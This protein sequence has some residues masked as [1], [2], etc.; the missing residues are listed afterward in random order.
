MRKM[1][2]SAATVLPEPVGAP[3]NTLQSWW[4]KEWKICDWMG[5]KWLKEKRSSSCGCFRAVFGSG[6]KSSS[7]VRVVRVAIQLHFM[8]VTTLTKTFP[9]FKANFFYFEVLLKMVIKMTISLCFKLKYK[10]V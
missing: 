5:L 8:L 3:N 2:S 6:C 10:N 4:Y 9:K 1:A 7:S